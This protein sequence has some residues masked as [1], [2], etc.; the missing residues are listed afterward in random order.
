MENRILDDHQ[1]K[2][3]R[4]R[5]QYVCRL[6]FA[7][8]MAIDLAVRRI[9]HRIAVCPGRQTADQRTGGHHGRTVRA[10]MCVRAGA[11]LAPCLAA[12]QNR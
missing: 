10:C 1:M 3:H 2:A 8:V 4:L 12:E 9:A 6:L 7:D 11:E 5:A